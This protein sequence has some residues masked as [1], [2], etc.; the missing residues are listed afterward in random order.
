MTEGVLTVSAGTSAE[1]AWDLMR[2]K[3]IHHLAVVDG[4]TIAG[5]ISD[6][7]MGGR[8]GAVV[9]RN[10]TVGELMTTRVVT[11]PPTTP[12][13]KAA[14][15]LRGRSIGCLIV[16]RNG[17]VRGIVTTADLLELLGGGVERPV[18]TPRRWTLNHRAPH[19]KQ[20]RAMGVW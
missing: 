10:R 17:R 14:N 9:R 4:R 20:H 11:V 6:R 8:Q 7:D 1:E 3:G 5:I 13:R 19:R 16:T 12:V 18:E 2:M 15:L